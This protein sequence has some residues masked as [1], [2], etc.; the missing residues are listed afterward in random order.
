MNGNLVTTQA[1]PFRRAR[2]DTQRAERREAILSTAET[3]LETRRVADL[4][5]NELSRQVGLAKSNVLHYFES[6]EAIL[7]ELYD[8]QWQEWTSELERRL[9]LEPAG[10][11]ALAEIEMVSRLIADT[12]SERPIF[13]ELT[14]AAAGVLEHNVSAD[15]A[16][17]YKSSSLANLDRLAIVVGARLGS[18]PPTSALLFVAAV[19]IAIGG[20]W[21]ST[22]PSEAMAAAY[23]AHPEL[24]AMTIDF[25]TAV[26]EFVAT[27]LVGLRER[28]PSV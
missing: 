20:V 24:A 3:M 4:S 12:V 7:L 27:V 17:D 11:S 16:A 2:S 22:Q 28:T 6:R 9:A 25:T 1:P 5:L 13:C 8:R 23:A 15:V 19:M 14:A 26:R 10:T 18:L 21:A